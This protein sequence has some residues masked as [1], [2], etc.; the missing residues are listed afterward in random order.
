[1]KKIIT[2]ITIDEQMYKAKIILN[3]IVIPREIQYQTLKNKNTHP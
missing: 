2:G 1:M 3:N